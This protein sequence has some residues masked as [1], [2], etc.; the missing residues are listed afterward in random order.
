VDDNFLQPQPLL[1]VNRMTTPAN[2]RWKLV[3]R[4]TGAEDTGID[5]RFSRCDR[6]KIHLVNELKSE[7]SHASPLP[8]PRAGCF[9]LVASN[10]SSNR[11]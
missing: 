1:D 7:P 3:D 5:W 4:A 2:M 9:L 11:T 6:V 8:R 10:G